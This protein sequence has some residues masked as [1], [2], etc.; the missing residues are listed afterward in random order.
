MRT[1][2]PLDSFWPLQ[3]APLDTGGDTG[4]DTPAVTHVLMRADRGALVLR[5]EEAAGMP[6]GAKGIHSREAP[7]AWREVE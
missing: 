4:S 6:D 1:G 7:P 3:C 5:G 2:W